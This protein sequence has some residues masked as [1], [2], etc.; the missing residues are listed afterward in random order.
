MAWWGGHALPRT[1]YNLDDVVLYGDHWFVVG[2]PE[3]S[4]DRFT[5][6]VYAAAKAYTMG[7]ASVDRTLKRFGQK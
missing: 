6:S 5:R 1:H 4:D 3:G 2:V 7:A